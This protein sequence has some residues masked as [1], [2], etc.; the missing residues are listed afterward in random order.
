MSL[1][2]R[3]LAALLAGCAALATSAPAVVLV[4]ASG[5][6][7]AASAPVTVRIPRR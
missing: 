4:S 1:R 7:S 3:A 5:T 2:R 6:P